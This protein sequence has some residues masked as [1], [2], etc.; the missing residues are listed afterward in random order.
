MD[1]FKLTLV[2]NSEPIILVAECKNN[3]VLIYSFDLCC[4]QKV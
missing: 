4:G 3:D 2:S 1:D